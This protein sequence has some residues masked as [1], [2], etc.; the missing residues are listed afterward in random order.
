MKKII[1]AI[2]LLPFTAQAEI[3][4]TCKLTPT[5]TV[6]ITRN[7]KIADT[8]VYFIQSGNSIPRPAFGTEDESRGSNV[9]A[10]CAG[11]KSKAA[12]LLGEFTSNYMKGFALN[13]MGR[14]D[15]AEKIPPIMLYNSQ[16]SMMVIFKTDKKWDSS[17]IY[18]IYKISGKFIHT[19]E[20]YGLDAIPAKNGYEITNLARALH[21]I[22]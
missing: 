13:R 7:N 9:K 16:D 17:N 6:T 3:V 14:I 15:F 4:T 12:I 2:L 22:H 18:T 11:I 20:S 8:Y 19:D 10:V 21:K 5:E 1:L